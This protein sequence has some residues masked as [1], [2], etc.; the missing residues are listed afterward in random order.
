MRGQCATG[1]E[2]HA[3]GAGCSGPMEG[4]A[5]P[6]ALRPSVRLAAGVFGCADLSQALCRVDKRRHGAGQ[7]HLVQSCRICYNAA[8]QRPCPDLPA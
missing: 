3:S 4:S 7:F 5:D 6:A 1:Q 8:C 2:R